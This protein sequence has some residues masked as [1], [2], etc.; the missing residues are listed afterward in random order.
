M[1]TSNFSIR[2]KSNHF[3]VYICNNISVKMI[4]FLNILSRLE[5]RLILRHF[6]QQFCIN[7]AAVFKQSVSYG[8]SMI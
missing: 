3:P 4:Y 8:F 2:S 1:T 6:R 7:M 5:D